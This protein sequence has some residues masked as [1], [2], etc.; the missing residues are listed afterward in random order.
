[1]FYLT[2]DTIQ[3]SLSIYLKA[4]EVPVRP[5]LL[6]PDFGRF[7]FLPLE[8]N[9]VLFAIDSVF[10]EGVQG[11]VQGNAGSSLPF[12]TWMES[13]I[14]LLF[15]LCIVLFSLVYRNARGTFIDNFKNRLSPLK[16]QI[17]GHKGQVTTSEL[18]GELFMICQTIL[19]IAIF[20]F[21]YL[22]PP[23]YAPSS[24]WYYL[25]SL[26]VFF[27][28]LALIAGFKYAMYRAISTF[29]LSMDLKRWIGQYYQHAQL[30]GLF[31]FL[32]ILVFVFLQEYRNIMF[33]LVLF[34]FL[35]NRLVII[36]S[37]LN[38]FVKNK[39]GLLYFFVYLC[40]TEIAP[41]LLFYKGALSI[42]NIAGNYL[43]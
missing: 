17:P 21:I 9:R 34:L 40:G 41:Y 11:V 32:P 24:P 23:D 15:M 12:S 3:D 30:L 27:S 38:I 18:W 39:V 2:P 7:E 4:G 37:L 19:L 36:I 29:F 28:G 25:I 8:D 16:K 22:F 1:M 5:N 10:L 33:V 26:A 35:V 6:L 31:L 42:V 43:V 20:L 14:F 13:I